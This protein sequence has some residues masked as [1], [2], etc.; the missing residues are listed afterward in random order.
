MNAII[1][2]IGDELLQGFTQDTNSSWIGKTLLPYKIK[3]IKKISIGDSQ[4]QIISQIKNT[5]EEDFDLLFVTGGLGPTHDD[6]TKEALCKIMD[7]ELIFNE[8]YYL[9]LEKKFQQYSIKI[10]EMH[11]TQALQLKKANSIP[12]DKGTALGIHYSINK[13][14]LFFMPGV[15]LEMKGMILNYIIPDYISIKPEESIITI[16]T[17]GITESYLSE[18]VDSLMSK[19]SNLCKFAF[20]PSY[21]GVSFRI[22]KIDGSINLLE[23]KKD[24]WELM[25]P[26]AYGTNDDSLEFKLS[27]KLIKLNLTI[28][29]A[30]SCTG[31]LIGKL[32]TDISGSSKYFL[33]SITAYSNNLKQSLLDISKESLNDYGAVSEEIALEMAKAI[34]IKTGANIGISTTGISGPEGGTKSKPVGLVFIGLSTENESIVKKYNFNFGRNINRK[35][36][37]TRALNMVRLLIEKN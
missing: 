10:L 1:I 16:N 8:D 4:N 17:T 26:Y 24:F 14:Q 34:R 9:K 32:L 33:G 18:K 20:L 21:T 6:I 11:R 28:A 31:G 29:S 27:S 15:P 25:H 13:K 12:N 22:S 3:I 5:L 36:T 30:E 7:D 19:Y 23:V 2:T 37:A 35:M